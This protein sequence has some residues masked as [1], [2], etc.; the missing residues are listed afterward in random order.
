MPT[1]VAMAPSGETFISTT[2][3]RGPW[4]HVAPGAQ[5]A[6]PIE[7]ADVDR[8]VADHGFIRVDRAFATWTELDDDRN[9]RA[10]EAIAPVEIDVDELDRDDIDELLGVA[11]RWLGQ[12]ERA[13]AGRLVT[14][15]LRASVVKSSPALLDA[16]SAILE[17]ATESTTSSYV[18]SA[19][20]PVKQMAHRRWDTLELAAA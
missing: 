9:R 17:R 16:I 3:T 1:L 11:E 2:S 19:E 13:R 4:L 10:A 6:G 8:A 18:R 15:L 20:D 7:P 14:R 12:H 5:G